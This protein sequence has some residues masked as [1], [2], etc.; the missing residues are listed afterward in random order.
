[1]LSKEE[2]KNMKLFFNESI[3]KDNINSEILTIDFMTIALEYIQQLETKNQKLIEKLEEKLSINK[4]FTDCT[5][6]NN[7]CNSYATCKLA[8]EILEILKEKMMFNTYNAGNTNLKIN[9]C[10]GGI[11]KT[12][13]ESWFVRLYLHG[14]IA[15]TLFKDPNLIYPNKDYTNKVILQ[16]ILTADKDYV[17]AE[18]INE[19]DFEK[20]FENEKGENDEY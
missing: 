3:K 14:D 15:R 9:S 7:T 2:I 19:K 18:I 17:I 5:Y 11:Y 4:S 12:Y 16:I 8:K 1:M 10:S 20:Y 6:C 13:K